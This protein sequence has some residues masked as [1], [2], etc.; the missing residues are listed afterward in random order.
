MLKLA[1]PCE[2]PSIGFAILRLS[3]I[4]LN[5]N[6]RAENRYTHG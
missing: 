6:L 1:G 3:N 4:T 2:G 5:E